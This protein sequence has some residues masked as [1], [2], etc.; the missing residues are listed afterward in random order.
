MTLSGLDPPIHLGMGWEGFYLN[1]FR[2]HGYRFA[3][4]NILNPTW[5]GV[6]GKS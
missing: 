4:T 6:R 5:G 2:T 3:A 1:E